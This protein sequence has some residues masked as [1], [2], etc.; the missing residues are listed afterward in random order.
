MMRERTRE[1]RAEELRERHDVWMLNLRF[2]LILTV[3]IAAVIEPVMR[4]F[5]LLHVLYVWI[6]LFHMP[7]FAFVTGYFARGNLHGRRGIE[8]LLKIGWQYLLF[9]TVYSLLD[10]L[11]FHVSSDGPSFFVPYLMLWFLAAHLGWRLMMKAMASLTAGTAVTLSALLGI[12]AGFWGGDGDLLG[13]SRMFV[14]LPFF[15]AGYKLCPERLTAVFR[16]TRRVRLAILPVLLLAAVRFDLA[17]GAIDWLYGRFTYAELDTSVWIGAAAR[18]AFYALQTAAAAGILALVPQ[19]AR[20]W[21]GMGKRTLYVFLLH[22]LF[23]RS[24]IA[25]EGFE[26]IRTGA[27]ILGLLAAG[28]LLTVMLAHPVIQRLTGRIV[29]R[30]MHAAA[31]LAAKLAGA[32]R[33]PVRSTR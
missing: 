12:A 28:V 22:G 11:F 14:F 30:P 18:T 15:A 19:H 9:Q 2:I 23:V 8:A 31:D 1:S 3:V 21:T 6:Y 32:V 4:R 7:L 29:D 13:L 5:E 26:A 10:V 24:W 33:P 25:L 16:K 17:P 27:D 20:G